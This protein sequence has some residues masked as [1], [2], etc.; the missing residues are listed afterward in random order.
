MTTNSKGVRIETILGCDFDE[1]AKDA[2]RGWQ[3]CMVYNKKMW[4]F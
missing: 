2:V 4:M 3:W 1:Q